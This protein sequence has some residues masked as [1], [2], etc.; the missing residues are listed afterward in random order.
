[1]LQS[2]QDALHWSNILRA[3]NLSWHM[4]CWSEQ[5]LETVSNGAVLRLR[6]QVFAKQVWAY[7][8]C[9]KQQGK[10]HFMPTGT[11][12]ILM[13]KSAYDCGANLPIAPFGHC[14]C[15][16]LLQDLGWACLYY[17]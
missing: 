4:T 8:V 10:K 16:R 3:I 17:L 7:G 15:P 14:C 13:P 6:A 11:G 2:K 9:L 5:M 1:M 12:I